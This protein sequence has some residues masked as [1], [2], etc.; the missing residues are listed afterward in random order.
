MYGWKSDFGW[1]VRG[2]TSSGQYL[3]CCDHNSGG[4]SDKSAKSTVTCWLTMVWENSNMEISS[5]VFLTRV[6]PANNVFYS[7]HP[8][9]L[10]SVLGFYFMGLKSASCRCL[11]TQGSECV[12]CHPAGWA[13][14]MCG[15]CMWSIIQLLLCMRLRYRNSNFLITFS[16]PYILTLVIWLFWYMCCA[17]ISFS[18]FCN[19]SICFLLAFSSR[20]IS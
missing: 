6:V 18:L 4:T 5:A 13:S 8:S 1:I 9:V 20:L 14:D 12:Y 17:S 16:T 7:H 3:L 10:H 15:P 11:Q 19:S 2:V